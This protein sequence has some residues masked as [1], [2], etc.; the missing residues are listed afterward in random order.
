MKKFFLLLFFLTILPSILAVEF[1]MN[2]VFNQ[3]ETI[4]ARVSGTFLN[5]ITSENI[6]FYRGHV[7][8]PIGYGVSKLG[9]DYY[10][11]ALTSGKSADNYSISIENVQYMKGSEIVSDKII[12]NFSIS[13]Q[14]ADFSVSKGFVATSEDFYLE[15]QNLQDKELTISIDT[16]L[17]NSTKGILISS[18]KSTESSISL[19]S[20]ETKKIN[21][22]IEGAQNPIQTIELKTE[23]LTYKIPVYIFA[24]FEEIQTGPFGFDPSVLS[25][26]VPT[27]SKEEIAIY[28][29]NSED[30]E[31]KDVLLL[32]SGSLNS[33]VTL[34]ESSIKN[35]AS[36]SGIQIE[37]SFFSKTEKKVEGTI[38]ALYNNKTISSLISVNFVGNYTA[39]N[40]TPSIT[41]RTCSQM[42]G[43]I[44]NSNQECNVK[45]IYA[46]D[47]V[48][49]TGICE[50]T[51]SSGSTGTIVG[52][53][54]L[55]IIIAGFA[56]FYMRYKKAKKPVNLLE[57]AKGKDSSNNKI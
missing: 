13:N 42:N 17:E 53:I 18:S 37:L 43:T 36:N 54:L 46:E 57:I 40:E 15:V 23:N 10:I 5:P 41:E 49:C 33:S 32:L 6:F 16:T 31:M 4:I 47:N 29:F 25:I 9:E 24:S 38:S 19:N 1:E 20:G 7:Q 12:K 45:T 21:F 30:V 3:G 22:Q 34:S 55:I 2:E 39:K 44:C 56:F 27:N 14:I 28:F 26:S 52:I 11:Y 48:C 51:D 8:I 35:L 50:S